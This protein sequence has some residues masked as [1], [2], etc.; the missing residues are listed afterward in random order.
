MECT[1]NVDPL[2]PVHR[3]VLDARAAVA[4]RALIEQSIATWTELN[5]TQPATEGHLLDLNNRFYPAEA[6]AA[7]NAARSNARLLELNR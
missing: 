3:A 5:V 6:V 7:T 1:G 4:R 2:V